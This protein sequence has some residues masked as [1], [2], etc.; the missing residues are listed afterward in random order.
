MLL[1]IILCSIALTIVCGGE[2]KQAVEGGKLVKIAIW[3]DRRQADPLLFEY[4]DDEK[5]LVR[6]RSAYALAM[7]EAEG[8]SSHISEL[9][10]D[11]HPMVVL[12]AIFALG[13]VGDSLQVDKLIPLT[14]SDNPDIRNEA[15][16]TLG[17]LGGKKAVNHLMNLSYDSLPEI[18]ARACEGLWRADADTAVQRLIELSRDSVIAVEYEAVYAL[19]R[20][21]NPEAATR[22]RFV[23]RDTVPEIRR[24]AAK[25]LGAMSDSGALIKLT[26]ALARETDW[27]AK[28]SIIGAIKKV[29]SKKAIKALLNMLSDNEHPLV[30]ASAMDAI[31]H[32]KIDALIPRIRPFLEHEDAYLKGASIDAL[33][34]LGDRTLLDNTVIDPDQV[35]WYVRMKT[36]E[37]L[38]YVKSRKASQLLTKLV[39]DPDP[40]VRAAALASLNAVD[41]ANLNQFIADALED[42]SLVVILTAVDLVSSRQ[43]TE[44]IED[45]EAIYNTAGADNLDLRFGIAYSLQDWIADSSLENEEAEILFELVLK[46]DHRAVRKLAIEAYAKTGQDLSDQLGYFETDIRAET[47]DKYYR[48]YASNPIAVL[49]TTKSRIK[50]RLLPNLAPKT[51]ANF[52]QL[53]ESGYFDNSIFHRVVPSFVIQDGDPTGTGM[54]GPGYTI[55]SEFNRKSYERGTVGM[56][57]AGKDTGGSQFFI[58]H[59]AQ[60][61]LNGR[62][63]AF[64]QVIS[65]MHLGDNLVVGDSLNSVEIIYPE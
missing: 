41:Y 38:Q 28:A 40:R 37:A 47:Y 42:S 26:E 39:A 20:L 65:G 51:V 6:A 55:R 24:G 43:M 25:A 32:I 3:E 57:H 63:T 59:S 60:P 64:G 2:K 44:H 56:A 18:R 5:P 21:A 8:A 62:Y 30:T 11:D 53:A 34:R 16:V 13:L 36:A 12:E 7:I 33:A 31:A 14:K 4:L 48:K 35:S 23:L 50:V 1:L 61:H 10:S 17:K 29:G 15:I 45:I 49:N 19:S 9:L 52:I 22:M 46:D 58:C 54:G 27:Q